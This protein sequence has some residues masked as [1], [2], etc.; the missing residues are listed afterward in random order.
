MPTLS[1]VMVQHVLV[2]EAKEAKVM[3]PWQRN[4]ILNIFFNQKTISAK[5][6]YS[7]I[8]GSL[9]LHHYIIL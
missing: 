7:Y 6:Y 8:D 5:S 2:R 9:L 4:V 3:G 1:I